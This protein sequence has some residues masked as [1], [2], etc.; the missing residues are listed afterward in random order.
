MTGR[1]TALKGVLDVS[2]AAIILTF[3]AL[4]VYHEG[5]RNRKDLTR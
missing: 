4:Q 3:N 5:M 1:D 2:I